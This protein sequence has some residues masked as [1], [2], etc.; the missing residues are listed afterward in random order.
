MWIV[1]QTVCKGC[2]VSG[3]G[4]AFNTCDVIVRLLFYHSFRVLFCLFSISLQQISYNYNKRTKTKFNLG[5]DFHLKLYQFI[6]LP[7]PCHLA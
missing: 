2:K 3:F 6:T 4:S 7:P 1:E 5:L